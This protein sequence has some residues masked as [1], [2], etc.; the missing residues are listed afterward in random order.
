MRRRP[1]E[2]SK[3]ARVCNILGWIGIVGTVASLFSGWAWIAGLFSWLNVQYLVL[4]TLALP[5]WLRLRRKKTLAA[6]ALVIGLN[7]YMI[8]P[9]FVSTTSDVSGGRKFQLVIFNVLRTNTEMEQ[10]LEEAVSGDPDFLFLMETGPK[11]P[12][13][14]ESLDENYPHRKVLCREDHTGVVFLSKHP[15]Q[16]LK[17]VRDVAGGNLPLDVRFSIEGEEFRMILTHPLPPIPPSNGRDRNEQLLELAASV[18]DDTPTILAG[19]LNVTPWSA[20]FHA[21]LDAGELTDLSKGYGITPTLAPLPS[22]FGGV[23]VDHVL[24]NNGIAVTNFAVG[25]T[26]YS[27]HRPVS[28]TF[29]ISQ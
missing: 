27:D 8:V 20:H 26:Q 6:A 29:S 23:K 25:V 18:S 7:L 11:W 17:V 3:P 19:D 13:V 12:A 22:W 2:H 16:S 14:L 1:D 10:T 15:W 9:Y 28:T 24:A 21:V 5:L 4:T